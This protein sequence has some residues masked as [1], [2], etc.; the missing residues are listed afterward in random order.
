MSTGNG[1][2][3]F[4]LSPLGYK[5]KNT[6]GLSALLILYPSTGHK[7]NQRQK[8]TKRKDKEKEKKEGG[9]CFWI[10]IRLPRGGGG[11][12]DLETMNLKEPS[13]KLQKQ[14]SFDREEGTF[15]KL[16]VSGQKLQGHSFLGGHPLWDGLFSDAA[17]RESP[18]LLQITPVNP[19]N[20]LS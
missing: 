5:S 15:P 4:P 17:A 12:E 6:S 10:E 14:S 7:T 11:S 13:L 19:S 18:M 9:T 20:K 1:L 16:P 3:V 2:C 8:S